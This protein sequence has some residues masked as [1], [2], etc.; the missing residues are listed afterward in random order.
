MCL[1]DRLYSVP[2][3]TLEKIFLANSECQHQFEPG[4]AALIIKAALRGTVI[5]K[6]T[7]LLLIPLSHWF[8]SLLRGNYCQPLPTANGWNQVPVHPHPSMFTTCLPTLERTPLLLCLA[9]RFRQTMQ[10]FKR[11]CYFPLHLCMEKLSKSESI[12]L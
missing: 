2:L 12:H 9:P 5:Q 11:D 6:H 10:V 4:S 8:F 7:L 3:S 1:N